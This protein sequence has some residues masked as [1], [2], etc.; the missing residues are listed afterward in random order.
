[1]TEKET[2]SHSGSTADNEELRTVAGDDALFEESCENHDCCGGH[3]HSEETE[4]TTEKK[5]TDWKL[6]AAYLAA[7]VENMQKRFMR[8]AIESRKFANEDIL[9]R[10]VPVLD[11]LCLA[12]DAAAKTKNQ[13]ENEDLHSSKVFQSFIQG[14]EMTAKHFEQVLAASGVEFVETEGKEFDPNLHEALGQTS[15]EGVANNIITEVFQRGFKLGGRVIR[16]AKVM[17]NKINS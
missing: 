14:V 11:T 17:V 15:K 5:E 3:H 7:E 12:L 8:E 16:P 1:M 6:Q 4:K 9:K 13:K 10:I 2:K